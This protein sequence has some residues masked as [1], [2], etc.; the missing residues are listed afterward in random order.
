MLLPLLQCVFFSKTMHLHIWLLWC[1]MLFVVY[2]N[3]PG[4]Q[5][6]QISP[7]LNT[8]G[9]WWSRN[10]LFLQSLPQPL[11]NCDNWCKML[12]I[13]YRRTI[14]STFMTVCLHEYMPVLPPEEVTLW[15]DLAVW[16]PLTCVSFVLNLLSYR[17]SYNDK[18]PVTS[19]C[20]TMNLSLRVL[21]FFPAVYILYIYTV[22]ILYI[23]THT[24]THTEWFSKSVQKLNRT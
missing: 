10:L 8:Y 24:H 17:Y 23:Y 9:T 11:L 14:F 1:N 18:L 6:P 7:Q 13:I 15:N 2:N 4:Q 21:H 16:A 3:C 5:D 22:Y 20:N 19:I 12:G